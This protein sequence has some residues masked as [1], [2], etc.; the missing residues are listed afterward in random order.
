[1]SEYDDD[2][3]KSAYNEGYRDYLKN[4]AK[5]D[6]PYDDLEMKAAWLDGWN[7]AYEDDGHVGRS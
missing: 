2:N 1:M 6:C 7:D 3:L 4:V 5:L